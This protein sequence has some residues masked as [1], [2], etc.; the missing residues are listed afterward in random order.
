[1]KIDHEGI[2]GPPLLLLFLLQTVMVS[3]KIVSPGGMTWAQ[4]LLPL[5]IVA[6]GA[7]ELLIMLL[8]H[9]AISWVIERR[10]R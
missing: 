8:I 7:V 3:L 5:V 10:N 1:M 4:S 6:V 9:V 2:Y